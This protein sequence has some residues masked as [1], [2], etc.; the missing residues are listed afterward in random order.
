MRYTIPRAGDNPL[1]PR[2][3]VGRPTLGSIRQ[4][5]MT[6]MKKTMIASKNHNGRVTIF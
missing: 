1:A 3:P 6:C 2:D 4:E 5:R